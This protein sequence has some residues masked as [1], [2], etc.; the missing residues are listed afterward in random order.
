MLTSERFHC[1]PKLVV[2][3][4]GAG[5]F[6]V[7]VP[8]EPAPLRFSTSAWRAITE[9]AG[10][11][12]TIEELRNRL[13]DDNWEQEFVC[14]ENYIEWLLS[15][16]VL[17]RVEVFSES[18]GDQSLKD[19][20]AVEA[21]GQASESLSH[22]ASHGIELLTFNPNWPRAVRNFFL[23]LLNL[24]IVMAAPM[25]LIIFAYSLFFL[26]TP[27]PSTLKLLGPSS[28]TSS[29]LNPLEQ[30][31][32]GLLSVNLVSTALTWFAQSVTGL[33]D[34]K[35][36]LRFLYG[37]IPR[38]GVNN[39]QIP[40]N[41]TQN[42]SQK[43]ARQALLCAAQPLLTRLW[44]ATAVVLLLAS[45]RLQSGLAG[46][47]IYTIANSIL[48]ISLVTGIFLALPFRIS[49]GYQLMILLT[50]L[51]PN[52][53]VLSMRRLYLTTYALGNWLRDRDESSWIAL[54]GSVRSWRD[55]WILIFAL[56]TI[57]LF[58]GEFLLVLTLLIP[59]L[60]SESP[61]IFGEATELILTLVLATLLI[62][63][64]KSLV[65]PKLQRLGGLFPA[66]KTAA[67]E[68]RALSQLKINSTTTSPAHPRFHQLS[69]LI[70][71]FIILVL[72]YPINRTVTGSVEVS[73][74]RDLTVRASDDVRITKI[75]QN[76]PST[77]VI[78][79]GKPLIELQSQRLT[80]DLYRTNSDLTLQTKE[81]RTLRQKRESDQKVLREIRATLNISRQAA[82]VLDKQLKIYQSL[83]AQGAYSPKMVQDALLQ[84]LQ[85]E[86]DDR[87]KIRQLLE[88]QTD[89]AQVQVSIEMTEQT[90]VQS[91]DWLRSLMQEQ[92]QL[93]VKM[94]FDGLITSSTSGLMGSF[95]PK[96]ESLLELKQG[97][98]DIVD[99][100][101][102]DHD[103]SLVKPGQTAEIRL[104]AEQSRGIPALVKSIRPTGELVDNKVFF[105]ASLKLA[106]PLSP[107]LLQSSGAARINTGKTN[108]LLA[109]LNSVSRFIL[110]DLWSWTP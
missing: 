61:N 81:L 14:V 108:L 45:G 26:L 20:T 59:G 27:A 88:V 3:A 47:E 16:R 21:L 92:S 105:Q 107:Q 89:L 30:I 49:P 70:G 24:Q 51:P 109:F 44:L 99:I 1:N 100:L 7:Y 58:I 55:G 85:L 50:E 60:A 4:L 87:E 23:H 6:V 104:Y 79:A 31:V 96:G 28:F 56:S 82:E 94:P 42:S 83:A 17:L 39:I 29:Q 95:V 77:E 5:G 102:P 38:L 15:K 110:V 25:L 19:S 106:K 10:L 2:S 97:S 41:S 35:V 13:S 80:Q 32:I 69:V 8:P 37:Y 34:G 103:R 9:L 67:R 74:E 11:D 52:L 40:P 86:E 53:L 43:F 72:L 93:N 71:I 46:A 84:V 57:L 48:Q 62:G 36:V 33:G 78:T 12:L 73:T 91:R 65:M 18:L 54:K 66:S 90:I 64:A 76:G 63:F 98:L 75:Y 101:I 68:D 22:Q